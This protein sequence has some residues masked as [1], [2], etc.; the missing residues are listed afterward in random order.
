MKLGITIVMA[1]LISI[2]GY[3]W[4]LPDQKTQADDQ[5]KQESMAKN[6]SNSH[7]YVFIK[8]QQANQNINTLSSNQQARPALNFIDQAGLSADIHRYL[9][10]KTTSFKKSSKVQAPNKRSH[11]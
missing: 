3:C 10:T 2:C 8:I 11:K 6:A 9:D 4:L 7:Q 1:G 5:T